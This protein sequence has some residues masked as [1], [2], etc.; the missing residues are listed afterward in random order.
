MTQLEQLKE[1]DDPRN[2]PTIAKLTEQLGRTVGAFSD[3][4]VIEE[5]SF[6]DAMDRM[7]EM[8]KERKKELEAKGENPAEA[9]V[10]N[11]DLIG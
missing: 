4:V 10:Y 3:K 2:A 7:L 8:R 6:D 1:Q 9:Y 5:V 11:P